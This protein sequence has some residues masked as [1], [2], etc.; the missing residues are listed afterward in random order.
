[1]R[2]LTLFILSLFCVPFLT[3]ILRAILPKIFK[4]LKS[5]ER[6]ASAGRETYAPKFLR[7]GLIYLAVLFFVIGIVLAVFTFIANPFNIFLL[8]ISILWIIPEALICLAFLKF[9]IKIEYSMGGLT[10]INFFG[11]RKDYTYD[12]IERVEGGASEN[13]KI[14]INGKKITIFNCFIGSTEFIQF[15]RSNLPGKKMPTKDDG[16]NVH[17]ERVKNVF[18]GLLG[19]QTV[20]EIFCDTQEQDG[21]TENNE[22]GK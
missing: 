19:R 8:V 2:I 15:L 10:Y 9:F 11:V 16:I 5:D 13:K 17:D 6:I 1:M 22:K 4:K 18:A 3:L 14:Y 7:I 21:G 12:Q 20:D